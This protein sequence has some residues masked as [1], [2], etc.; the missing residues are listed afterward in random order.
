MALTLDQQLAQLPS[1]VQARLAHHR[2]D[3]ARFKLLAARLRT[4]NAEDNFVKGEIRPPR[5]QDIGA[6]PAADSPEYESLRALGEQAL[7]EGRVA[8]LVLAGGMATR[9]GGVIK[10]LVDAIPGKS[11]LDLR[12]AE[13]R[14]IERRY[15]AAPP[16]WLMTSHSTDAGIREAL[17]SDLDGVR[18]ATFTQHLSLRVTPAGDVFL[19]KNGEPSEHAPGH[20]DLPDA[21]RESGLLQAFVARGGK[22]IMLTNIDNMGGTLDPVTIG[23]HLARGLP[24]TSEVVDKLPTDKGGIPAWVDDTLCIL[25]EFRIPPSFDPKTVR[26]FATNVFYFDAQA[27]LDLD[28]NWTYFTVHKKVDDQP[29]VQFERLVNEVTSALP[30]AYLHL[31]RTGDTSRFLPVKDNDELALREPEILAVVRARGIV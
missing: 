6:L 3:A 17:G 7:R 25:E 28:M 15:G 12:R 24:V 21:L 27:L 22:V 9:M 1:D 10:A 19:D 30:T 18:I 16:L 11:F 8:L 2:F 31:P 26:V 14:H 23:F 20:G 13:L 4:E 29:V 5:P